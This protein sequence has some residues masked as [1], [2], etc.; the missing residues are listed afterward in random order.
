DALLAGRSGAGPI[1]H[2]DATE[3]YDC[4]FACEVKGFQPEQYMDRKEARRT[5]RFAQFALAAA[6]QAM[7]RAGLDRTDAS[8][9]RDRTGVLIGSGIGGISTLAA[10][11]RVV[12][13]KG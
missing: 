6:Q 11:A 3:D 9:D 4:R 12:A 1:T 10:P 13:E 8:F 5:D 7:E 2:F